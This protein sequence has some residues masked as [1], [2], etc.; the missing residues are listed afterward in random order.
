MSRAS[1]LIPRRSN[2]IELQ[3]ILVGTV[4][5]GEETAAATR[6]GS[7]MILSRKLN[8]ND[9]FKAN[10]VGATSGAVGGYVLQVDH[11]PFGSSTP[12]GTWQTIGS[13]AA[14]G[15][16][17][18]EAVFSGRQIGLAVAAA[19]AVLDPRVVAIRARPG[20]GVLAITN[21]V[22]TSNVATITLSAPHTLIVGDT[23]TVGCSN[24][25]VNGTFTIT[26]VTSTTFSYASTQANISTA[27]AT[28]TVTNGQAVPSNIG[29][30][31]LSPVM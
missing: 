2:A 13:I 14:N 9:V 11:V 19:A 26:A 20:T 23:I 8:G 31:W 10:L 3:H 17:E 28:G 27:A 25:L 4:R 12:N 6:D 30:L 21:V 18:V 1:G 22:L 15:V 5:Q 7:Q 24:P 29:Y 16:N